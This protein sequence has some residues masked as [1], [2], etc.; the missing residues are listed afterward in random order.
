MSISGSCWKDPSTGPRQQPLAGLLQSAWT[1]PWTVATSLV[2]QSSLWQQLSAGQLIADSST[3]RTTV[4]KSPQFFQKISP[5]P[6]EVVSAKQ[7]HAKCFT[8]ILPLNS[9]LL[10]KAVEFLNWKKVSLS[11]TPYF[12]EE[13]QASETCSDCLLLYRESSLNQDIL[14]LPPSPPKSKATSTSYLCCKML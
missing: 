10:I 2:G 12:E 6:S 11:S 9:L 3:E 13:I 5:K 7:I 14:S 4:L 1:W 8:P